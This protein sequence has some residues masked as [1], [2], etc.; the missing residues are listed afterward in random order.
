MALE[1][2]TKITDADLLALGEDVRAEVIDGEM[3]IQMSSNYGEHGF[4]TILLAGYLT[5]FVR[6]HKLGRVFGDMTAFKFEEFPEGGIKGARVPDAAYVSYERLP[7]DAPLD[8]ILAIVPDIVVEVISKSEAHTDVLTKMNYYLDKGVRLV[9]HILPS[10][11]QVHIYGPDRAP[12]VLGV[13]DTLEGGDVL[14]GFVLPV[15]LLFE[16]NDDLHI[17]VMKSLLGA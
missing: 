7:A 11:R 2:K 3:V 9:I 10:L 15:V 14:P 12:T 13:S 16:E 1:A 6:A 4:H 17:Q 8:V 5:A